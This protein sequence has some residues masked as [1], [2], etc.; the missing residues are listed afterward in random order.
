MNNKNN[1]LDYVVNPKRGKVHT[2]FIIAPQDKLSELEKEVQHSPVQLKKRKR[3][4]VIEPPY[5]WLGSKYIKAE[6]WEDLSDDERVWLCVGNQQ[7][8][9]GE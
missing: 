5:K 9:F 4:Q 7:E 1:K 6:L 8:L 3:K 2:S